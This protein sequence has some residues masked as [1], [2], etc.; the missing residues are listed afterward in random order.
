MI[1][2]RNF[3]FATKYFDYESNTEINE[4]SY[5]KI[6]GWYKFV[7]GLLTALLVMDENLYFLFG[8][9]KFLIMD[10][11]SML[12]KEVSEVEQVCTL[13]NRN[14]MLVGFPYLKSDSKL[15]ISPFEYID[16]EDIEWEKFMMNI[17]NDRERKKSFVA[18]LNEY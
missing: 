1:L 4:I 11:H 8:E 16:D 9:D 18:N 6:N 15:N 2:L 14:D 3:D 7:N 17:I 5:P 13:M 10:S 12:L